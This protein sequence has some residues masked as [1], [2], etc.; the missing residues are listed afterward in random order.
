M[1]TRK[2]RSKYGSKWVPRDPIDRCFHGMSMTRPTASFR[3]SSMSCHPS[4][5]Q[6][7]VVRSWQAHLLAKIPADPVDGCPEILKSRLV[8]SIL[9]QNPS[10]KEDSVWCVLMCLCAPVWFVLNNDI[11]FVFNPKKSDNVRGCSRTKKD[12]TP[13]P[14]SPMGIQCAMVIAW[15]FNPEKCAQFFVLCKLPTRPLQNPKRI[16]S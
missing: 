11:P 3:S 15:W 2:K 7:V 13:S 14:K 6:S 16:E 12:K 5:W 1:A 9:H 8:A 4:T 10:Q